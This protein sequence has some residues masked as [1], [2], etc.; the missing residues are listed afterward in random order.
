M[1]HIATKKYFRT[2]N[3]FKKP[4]G[5]KKLTIIISLFLFVIAFSAKAQEMNQ[6][7]K[8]SYAIGVLIGKKITEEIQKSKM[9]QSIIE[10]IKEKTDFKSII[11]VLLEEKIKEKFQET[12]IDPKLLESVK[13]KIDF[14][15]IKEKIDLQSIKDELRDI[16]IGVILKDNFKN[17]EIDTNIVESIK[18]FLYEKIDI[19]F[20]GAGA[21]DILKGECKLPKEEIET[22]LGEL[23]QV[24]DDFEKL[25]NANQSN[26][27][28]NESGSSSCSKV[29]YS[30]LANRLGTLSW[31]YLIIKDFKQAEKSAL[32]A[33]KYD[34]TQTWVK[35]NLAHALLFQ[36]RFSKAEKIYKE[37]SQTIN[38]NNETY[39]RVLLEDFDD[40]EKAGAIP[41]KHKADVE[42]IKKMLKE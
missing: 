26:E 32:Q 4:V 36:N 25:I 29:D 14:K 35:T 1:L 11:G 16:F 10:S 12:G 7:E 33:L 17:S 40:L 6:K 27:N 21:L 41:E 18:A 24:K 28:K 34:I 9:D 2:Q 30:V 3:Y 42:K 20:I 13:E 8:S 15:G 31:N 39:T 38:K 19:K 22:I 23:N 37:L 5:M